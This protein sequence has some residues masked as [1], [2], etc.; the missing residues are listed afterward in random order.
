MSE[1]LFAVGVVDCCLA[2]PMKARTRASIPLGLNAAA[3]NSQDWCFPL[4]SVPL[5][6]RRLYTD[7]RLPF[8]R[9]ATCPVIGRAEME[10]DIVSPRGPAVFG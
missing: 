1:P 4:L 2:D 10:A 3:P 6:A 8:H 9:I 5:R 7:P